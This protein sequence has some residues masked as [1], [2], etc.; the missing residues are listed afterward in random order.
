MDGW[1]YACS[2]ILTDEHAVDGICGIAKGTAV[3][4]DT[5]RTD[6]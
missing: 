5:G 2:C 3:I 4:G 1:A 6:E